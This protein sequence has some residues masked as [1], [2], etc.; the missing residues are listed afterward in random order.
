MSL[1]LL[2]KD[3]IQDLEAFGREVDPTQQQQQL[4]STDNIVLDS[5]AL[6]MFSYSGFETPESSSQAKD[7]IQSNEK[8]NLLAQNDS[9]P[10]D[11]NSRSTSSSQVLDDRSNDVQAQSRQ[12]SFATK[13]LP[14]D[15]H[16]TANPQQ[17]PY[18][19]RQ[20]FHYGGYADDYYFTDN[21][22]EYASVD[23]LVSKRNESGAGGLW[24]C[25]F[26]W[27]RSPE[28][29]GIQVRQNDTIKEQANVTS[30]SSNDED[31]ESQGGSTNSNQLGER[32]SDK[33]RQAVIARLRLAQPEVKECTA[34]NIQHEQEC[35][36]GSNTSSRS[37]GNHSLNKKGLFNGIPVYDVS[38]LEEAKGE[39]APTYRASPIIK[40][41]LK[42]RSLSKNDEHVMKNGVINLS[43]LSNISDT[44]TTT[45][46]NMKNN[47]DTSIASQSR[48]NRRSLFPSYED[49]GKSTV[50]NKQ[51]SFT[52][53]ARVV[54]VKSKNDMTDDEKAD[55]WWRRSDYEDFRR[56]GRIITRAMLEGGSE[57]WL[58]G[59]PN[60]NKNK[61]NLSETV[62]ETGDIV[63]ATGDK[64]WHKFGHSRRGLEHVVS[65]EEGR[66]RQANVKNA[67]RVV[68]EEQSRQ[69]M[70]KREDPEKLRNV[71]LRHTSWARDLALA[72]GASDADAVECSF[73]EDRRSREFFLL[74]LSRTSPIASH[75][76]GR[77]VPEFMQPAFG[78]RPQSTSATR[79]NML[80]SQHL[81][82]N[83]AAQI[84]FRRHKNAGEKKDS[85]SSS[86]VETS[87]PLHDSTVSD[88]KS[89]DSLK[90]Q[91]AGFSAEGGSADMAAVLS[92]MGVGLTS[93]S[94]SK[95]DE[96]I[97]TM[98]VAS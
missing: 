13:Q 58:A 8:A 71:A 93:S 92:G 1:G 45:T 83:T 27:M 44:T 28:S 14:T 63:S 95:K 55:V 22:S 74:K 82:A 51:V 84:K 62:H 80:P 36:D 17:P 40:G 76:M 31:A 57:I 72:A 70:Y 2:A 48:S 77:H 85:S 18:V 11:N 54:T 67:I 42:K 88:S 78:P 66:Q 90:H 75:K 68:L 69:K 50:S 87:E 79:N 10:Q 91:A 94:T 37:S 16:D 59:N 30:T 60:N 61:A 23:F 24:A 98:K 3:S 21:A 47:K 6:N 64:W 52:P 26:P 25:L 56:T 15:Q 81:D 89:K 41:I 86:V 12:P 97:P 4:P 65:I 49:R 20:N 9:Q 38:P 73:A 35:S 19:S 43:Y 33:E 32:L 96:T 5:D 39:D 53:M 46:D 7:I 34:P 29:K